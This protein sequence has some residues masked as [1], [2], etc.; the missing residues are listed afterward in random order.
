[1]AINFV[2]SNQLYKALSRVDSYKAQQDL[3]KFIN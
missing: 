2:F 1:M 3:G